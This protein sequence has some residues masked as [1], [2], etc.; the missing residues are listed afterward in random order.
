MKTIIKLN[1]KIIEW[2]KERNIDKNGTVEAQSIKTIEEMSELIKGVCKDD[3][4][5]IKDSI[6]DVYVTLV[7]LCML[8]NEKIENI[9]NLYSKVVTPI[10]DKY[11]M[12]WKTSNIICFTVEKQEQKTFNEFF[13]QIICD[14]YY[15]IRRIAHF[16]KMT[17]KECVKSAYD[18]I[19]NRRG[20]MINGKFVKVEDMNV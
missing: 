8:K 13:E 6:G 5:L 2:A 19:K 10:K 1:E 3:I 14:I 15:T 4:S 7:I 17:L 16:Y 18:E 9:V 12:L 20:K 11:T